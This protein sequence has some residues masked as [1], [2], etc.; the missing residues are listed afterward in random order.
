MAPVSPLYRNP[1]AMNHS[2]LRLRK[3]LRSFLDGCFFFFIFF[4]KKHTFSCTT[5]ITKYT[6]LKGE[7]LNL[8]WLHSMKPMVILGR[9]HNSFLCDGNQHRSLGGHSPR[10]FLNFSNLQ[11]KPKMSE[12]FIES[13]LLTK[14]NNEFV[15]D[16]YVP[17]DT[18]KSPDKYQQLVPFSK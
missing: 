5:K 15:H 3:L 17:M 16:Y 14:I 8:R 12:I 2:W 1:L 7:I 6:I 10:S 4:G 13:H 9:I 18:H 11:Q